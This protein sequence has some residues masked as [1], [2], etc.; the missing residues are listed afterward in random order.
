[1]ASMPSVSDEDVRHFTALLE[2][3]SDQVG[4]IADGHKA[5]N[6]KMD[7]IATDTARARS[8]LEMVDVRLA[9]LEHKTG[10]IEGRLG[11]LEKQ[12]A[13]LTNDMHAV[14]NHLGLNGASKPARRKSP[15]KR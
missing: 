9:S 4:A 13:G 10:K 11:L 1:L 2:R 15:K 3:V 7:A 14:K 8:N 6:T 5:L 12:G